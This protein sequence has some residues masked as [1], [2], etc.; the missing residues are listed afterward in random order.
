MEKQA[1][2]LVE[3]DPGLGGQLRWALDNYNVQLVDNQADAMAAMRK[4]EGS[5]R[6]SV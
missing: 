3:D 2:L 4:N 1:V 5:V 6:S